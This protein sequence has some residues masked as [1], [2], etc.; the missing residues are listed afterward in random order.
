MQLCKV[1]LTVNYVSQ[2]SFKEI[3]LYNKNLYTKATHGYRKLLQVNVV[4][5]LGLNFCCPFA[6]RGFLSIYSLIANMENIELVNK[7]IHLFNKRPLFW[8]R[9][10]VDKRAWFLTNP[11]KNAIRS[12]SL[13]VS[14][15]TLNQ[16][17]TW[18]V[19]QN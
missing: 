18:N 10:K 14:V 2:P 15:R 7:K 8:I 19:V 3:Y 11:M 6:T 17:C 5:R 12:R 13:T 16:F 4:R 9:L 1:C